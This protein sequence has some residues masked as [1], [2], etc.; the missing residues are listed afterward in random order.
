MPALASGTVTFLSTDK[1]GSTMRNRR[2]APVEETE[3]EVLPGSDVDDDAAAHTSLENL[4][5]ESR[6]V[7]ERRDLCDAVEGVGGDIPRQA[8]PGGAPPVRRAQ[9]RVDAQ[10]VDSA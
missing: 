10:Q 4:A 7:R 3:G 5:G 2:P 6:H 1:A 8:F 9:R